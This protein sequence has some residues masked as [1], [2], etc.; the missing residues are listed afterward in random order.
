[1]SNPAFQPQL[2]VSMATTVN[3]ITTGSGS[4]MSSLDA[5]K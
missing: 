5:I 3:A 1:M 2:V 4:V